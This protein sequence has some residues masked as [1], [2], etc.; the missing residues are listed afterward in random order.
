MFKKLF[1]LLVVALIIYSGVLFAAPFYHYHTFKSDVEEIV[2]MRNV[3][4]KAML[5]R[6][7]ETAEGYNVPIEKKDIILTREKFYR[8][9]ISWEE[10]VNLLGLYERTFKFSIDTNT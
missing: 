10:T 8:A 7:V 6:I 9:R 5:E 4:H 2:Q 1:A 3:Q